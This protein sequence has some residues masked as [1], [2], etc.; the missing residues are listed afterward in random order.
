ML[1]DKLWKSILKSI[2]EEEEILVDLVN[3]KTGTER[4]S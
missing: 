4:S 1:E 2:Q 3:V